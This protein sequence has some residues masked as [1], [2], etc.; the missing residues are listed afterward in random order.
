MYRKFAM[1]FETHCIILFCFLRD[2]INDFFLLISTENFVLFGVSLL[3]GCV[4]G[5]IALLRSL[6]QSQHIHKLTRRQTK[7][8]ISIQ[9]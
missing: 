7:R 8:K 9:E 4:L 3:S 1:T 6:P 5:R 2:T